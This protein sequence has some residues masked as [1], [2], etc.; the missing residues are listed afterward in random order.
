VIR[1]ADK[2]GFLPIGSLRAEHDAR[3]RGW[4]NFTELAQAHPWDGGARPTTTLLHFPSATRA[5]MDIDTERRRSSTNQVS[6]LLGGN[7]RIAYG[8]NTR[9]SSAGAPCFTLDWRLL[10]ID[11]GESR[12]GGSGV[13]ATRIRQH[14][15]R[16]EVLDKIISQKLLY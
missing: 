14:L 7:G 8:H 9:P 13:P 15:E 4:V 12:W 3:L 16:V 2:P 10:A 11:A 5:A 6:S 1:V